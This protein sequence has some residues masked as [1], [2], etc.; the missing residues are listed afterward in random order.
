MVRKAVKVVGLVLAGLIGLLVVS[1]V[2]GEVYRNVASFPLA[3]EPPTWAL[4]GAEEVPFVITIDADGDR[5]ITQIWLAVLDDVGYLRTGNSRWYANLQRN[6]TLLLHLDG[7]AYTCGVQDVVL[8]SRQS[9]V[10]R[11]F[12]EKY[13]GRTEFFRAIGVQTDRVLELS[14]GEH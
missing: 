13:P 1:F 14:C 3:T 7:S 2:V 11:A 8:P 9:A 5:R 12:A 10:H 6:P 4:V